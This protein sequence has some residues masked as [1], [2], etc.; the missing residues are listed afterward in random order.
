[1]VQIKSKRALFFI[2]LLGLITPVFFASAATVI[3]TGYGW[4][5][6]IG[7]INFSP[8]DSNGN[9]IGVVIDSNNKLS[10]YAWSE[11][12]GWINFNPTG[13]D[14]TVDSGCGVK[15]NNNGTLIGSAWGENLGWVDFGSTVINSKGQFTGTASGD[16]VGT[17][18]FTNCGTGCGVQTDWQPI[19]GQ[20]GGTS[21]YAPTSYP[22]QTT[23]PQNTPTTPNTN[24]A[25]P[26]T[27]TPNTN[28]P[29]VAV[30]PLKTFYKTGEDV[31]VSGTADPYSEIILYWDVQYGI[32][33]ANSKGVWSVNFGKMAQG[34]HDT[35]ITAKDSLGNSKTVSIT[36]AVGQGQSVQPANPAKPSILPQVSPS[37][38]KKPASSMLQS[39]VQ[40]I[41]NGLKYLFSKK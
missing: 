16:I 13:T 40:I 39:L 20:S 2:I 17:I 9:F 36:I 12:Y 15:I 29:S 22:D 35:T 33:T 24:P 3:T 30:N 27:P 34:S 8:K 23:K 25:T 28:T 37:A 38:P 26:A 14:C 7:W 31:I 11:N 6:D 18:A 19:V 32:T 1:M 10:G 5:N 21:T 4:S 41:R